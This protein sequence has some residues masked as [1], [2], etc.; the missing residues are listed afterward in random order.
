MAAHIQTLGNN[1]NAMAI[2]EVNEIKESEIPD[3]EN[4]NLNPQIYYHF[5]ILQDHMNDTGDATELSGV[6]FVVT[7]K[8]EKPATP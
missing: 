6:V 4:N 1:Y 5:E 8:K 7:D 2:T 3:V